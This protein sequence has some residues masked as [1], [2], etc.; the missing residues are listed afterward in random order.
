MA[1]EQVQVDSFQHYAA[2]ATAKALLEAEGIAAELLHANSTDLWAGCL[3]EVRLR[4][5]IEQEERARALLAGLSRGGRLDDAPI[6]EGP[7]RCLACKEPL[8]AD[9]A[10]CPSCGFT[11]AGEETHLYA[12][13]PLPDSLLATAIAPVDS[14]RFALSTSQVARYVEWCDAEGLSV[15][16]WEV[17]GRGL[18]GHTVRERVEK[19]DGA[20]LR[21]AAAALPVEQAEPLYFSPTVVKSGAQGSAGT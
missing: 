19:G 6:A 18:V 5:P 20:A 14:Q 10:S 16:G 3:G 12:N 11:F 15:S 7:E 17:W 21:R 13:G 2:A 9:V 4:V 1:S 8:P